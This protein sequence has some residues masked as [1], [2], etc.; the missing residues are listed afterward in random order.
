MAVLHFRPS[1]LAT[2]AKLE[3]VLVKLI[4]SHVR[5]DFLKTTRSKSIAMHALAL[6][7]N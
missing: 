1:V 4:F 5:K 7:T 3:H 6:S 2:H